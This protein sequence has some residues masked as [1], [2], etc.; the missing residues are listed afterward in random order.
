MQDNGLLYLLNSSCITHRGECVSSLFIVLPLQHWLIVSDDVRNA[1]TKLRAER[2]KQWLVFPRWRCL[3]T[4]KT[5]RTCW[6]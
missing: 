5:S 3:K 4:G 6:H 2:D 1:V